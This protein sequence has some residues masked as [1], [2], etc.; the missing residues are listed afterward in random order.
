M[1]VSSRLRIGAVALLAALALT[2]ALV[3]TNHDGADASSPAYKPPRTDQAQLVL[4]LHDL[5]PGFLNADL[6]EEQED[7]IVCAALSRP[8]DTPPALAKFI[9]PFRPKGCIAIYSRLFSVPGE[10]RPPPLAGTGVMALGSA[11]AANSAWAVLPTLLGRLFHNVTPREVQTTARIGSATRLFHAKRLPYPYSRLGSKVTFL[12]W[13]SGNTLAAIM[14]VGS[15]YAD[16]DRFAAELAPRQQAHIRK[17]T[18]YTPAA[19]YDGEVGL[20]DPAIDI[21]IYWLGR[22]FRPGQGLPANKLYGSGYRGEPRPESDKGLVEEGPGAPLE[23]DYDNIRLGTWTSSTW[24]VFADS[25]A[26]RVVT[27]WKCTRTRTVALPEGSATIFA[28]YDKDFGRCPKRAPNVFTAWVE[29]GGV[30]VVVNAPFAADFIESGNPY[31]SFKGME[32]IVRALKL[33][34]RNVY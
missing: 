2:L 29:V 33:R 5:P 3:A 7:R 14:A 31:G 26:S 25:R 13:R 4:R 23:A 1:A 27:A 18:R 6:E 34:P 10:K 21:P 24:H 16:N 22:T 15:S 17:P 12:V 8:D 20:E 9:L 32:A 11:D 28:G 30:T 19:R